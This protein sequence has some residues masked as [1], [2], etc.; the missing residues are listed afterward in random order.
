MIR[1]WLSN[2]QIQEAHG[3]Y[4]AQLAVIEPVNILLGDYMKSVCS[5]ISVIRRQVEKIE[6]I[7]L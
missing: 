4:F 7:L 3:I 1:K 6:A 2:L 5:Y